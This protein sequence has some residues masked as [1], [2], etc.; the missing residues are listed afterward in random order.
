MAK[1][2]SQEREFEAVFEAS[3]FAL[4]VTRVHDGVTVGVNAAFERLLGCP[5]ATVIGK[6]T[7]DLMPGD[8]ES[9]SLIAAAMRGAAQ[10]ARRR[11]RPQDGDG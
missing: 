8:E 3:P 6:A 11:V 2:E 7:Q 4:A 1:A 5:R 10:P 9:R